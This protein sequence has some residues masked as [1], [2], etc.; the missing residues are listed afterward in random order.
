MKKRNASS[1]P[2]QPG[3]REGVPPGREDVFLGPG[4]AGLPADWQ[5]QV[6]PNRAA[7]GLDQGGLGETTEM[8]KARGK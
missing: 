4:R 3:R 1:D 2:S 8:E 6:D 5:G 7:L